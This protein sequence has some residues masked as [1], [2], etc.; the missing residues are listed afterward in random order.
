M[1]VRLCKHCGRPARS[2]PRHQCRT[3]SGNTR[4]PAQERENRLRK[5]YGIT[6]A[7]YE[8]LLVAQG[9]VCA[10]CHRP[11]GTRRLAVDHRHDAVA[12][13]RDG[14]RSLVRGLLC[15]R[16]NYYLV[17]RHMTPTRLRAAAAYMERPPAV[18]V[19]AALDI[20]NATATH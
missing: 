2:G 3:C 8:A 1:E 6:V 7:D 9:G 20:R 19:L 4:S 15:W 17:N 18:D 5:K 16:D 13:R 11:P 10:I 12:G 14:K